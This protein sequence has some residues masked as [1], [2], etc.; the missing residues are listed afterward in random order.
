MSVPS[1]SVKWMHSGMQGAPVLNNSWG[2]LTALLRACAVTGFNIRPVQ[3]MTCTGTMATVQCN[4]HGFVE[5]QVVKIEGA[6]QEGYNGEHRIVSVVD[7]NTVRITLAAALEPA[8]AASGQTLQMRAAALGFESL[9]DDGR[10]K[11]V[12]RSK[13]LLSPRNVLRVDDSCPAGYTTTWA[14]F[15]RVTMAQDMSDLDTFF[16]ARAPFDPLNPTKNEIP[17]GSG[18]DLYSGWY[19]WLYALSSDSSSATRLNLVPASG[20]R[21]WILIGDGRGFYLI[22][23]VVSGSERRLCYAFTDFASLK[24]ADA[25]STILMAHDAYNTVS[26]S[27]SYIQA[28]APLFR[29]GKSDGMILM[30]GYSGEGGNINCSP[31]TLNI[32]PG[33]STAVDSGYTDRVPYPSGAD[34]R[35]LLHPV[36]LFQSNYD[37]RGLLPGVLYV[38]QRQTLPDL[39]ILDSPVVPGK[40]VL[41]INIASGTGLQSGSIAFD[42]TGPWR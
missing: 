37:I 34:N 15:G 41:L 1:A 13:D 29:E 25:F 24:T 11:L 23:G 16:G 9:F 22:T 2:A 19:R 5:S 40:K 21:K 36:Y 32:V 12:L 3:S 26:S 38:L 31:I 6:E 10:Q 35:L 7:A 17:S 8:S 14:N 18:N 27:M 20:P 39:S 30:R 28:Y 4:G 33:V 42:I